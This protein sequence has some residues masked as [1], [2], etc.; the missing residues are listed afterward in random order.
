MRL[1]PRL[2]LS[3]VSLGTCSVWTNWRLLQGLAIRRALPLVT[4]KLPDRRGTAGHGSSGISA[5]VAKRARRR[6]LPAS[7]DT[8]GGGRAVKRERF[9]SNNDGGASSAP[10]DVQSE[11]GV[12]SRSWDSLRPTAAA[13]H[14]LGV[15]LTEV[16]WRAR[17]RYGGMAFDLGLFADRVKVRRAAVCRA[18]RSC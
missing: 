7:H 5:A 9:G 12:R 4:G 11:I 15:R 2:S 6:T 10:V 3:R 14:E 1:V 8:I 16:G 17:M 13:G 18:R